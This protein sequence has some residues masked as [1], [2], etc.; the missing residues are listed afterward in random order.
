MKILKFAGNICLRH[1]IGIAVSIIMLMPLYAMAENQQFLFSGITAVIAIALVYSCGW[2][3]GF[4]D[5]RKIKGFTPDKSLP[6]KSSLIYSILPFAFI[7][8]W[9]VAPDFMRAN[10]PIMNGDTEFFI[11]GCFI[12]GTPDFIYRIWQIAFCGFIPSGNAFAY[13]VVLLIEPVSVYIGYCVGLK[14][15]SIMEY[16]SAK[17]VFSSSD[18]DKKTGKKREDGFRR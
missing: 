5:A 4:R 2:H 11:K 8:V 3:Y 12:N 1:L 18:K 17:I 9:L 6:I 13:F 14:R 15:F 16:I 10:I 7:I